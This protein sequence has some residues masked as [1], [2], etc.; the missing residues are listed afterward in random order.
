MF[1]P[2]PLLPGVWIPNANVFLMLSE[3]FTIATLFLD[4]LFHDCLVGFAQLIVAH[5]RYG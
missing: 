3:H 1:G 5:G 2:C 4:L